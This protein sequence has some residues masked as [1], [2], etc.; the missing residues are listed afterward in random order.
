[1]LARMH[2]AEHLLTSVMRR[3]YGSPGVVETHFGP[4]KTKCDYPVDRSLDD[5]DLSRIEEAVNAEIAADHFVTVMQIPRS[6][7]EGV[8]DLSRVPSAVDV[9]RI[10]RIGDFDRTACVGEHVERTS[11]IGRFILRSAEMKDERT[12]RLRFSLRTQS[13]A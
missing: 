4:A 6:E 8:L 11:Q 13:G 10:V 1:M 9:I 5:A 3:V 7:A 12:V 2:S